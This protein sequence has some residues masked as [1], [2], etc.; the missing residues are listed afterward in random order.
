VHVRLATTDG[1]DAARVAVEDTAM[2]GDES[3]VAAD[4]VEVVGG[5]VREQFDELGV[6]WHVAVG[7]EFADRD[8]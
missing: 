3:K 2:V 8:A 1:H 6:Q 4:V 5:P 7:A